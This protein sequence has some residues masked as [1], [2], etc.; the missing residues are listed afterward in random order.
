MRVKIHK[1]FE[2]FQH[3]L[4]AAPEASVVHSLAASPVLGEFLEDLSP[5][6]RR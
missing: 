5:D 1:L 2:N 4:E 6:A 3:A